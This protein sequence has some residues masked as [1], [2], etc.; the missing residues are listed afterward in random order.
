MTTYPWLALRGRKFYL[1]APVPQD[2]RETFGKAEITKSLRTSDR[3]EAIARLWKEAAIVQ[4]TFESHRRALARLHQPP[5]A[6]LTDAQIKA[7]GDAYYANLLE[8]DESVRLEGFEGRDFDEDAGWLDVLDGVNR[9]EFARGQLSVFMTDEAEDALASD[10]F[11]LRLADNSPSWP[12][13]IRAIYAA[14][15]EAA[16]ARRLRNAGDVIETPKPP[17]TPAAASSKPTLDEAK[18]FYIK[19][20]ITGNEFARR[21]RVV[22]IDAMMKNIEKA[23]GTIPALPDWTVD[24]AYK[25]RD[26]LLTKPKANGK[27]TLSP[28]SVRRGLNDIKG[29]FSLYKQKKMRALENPFSG[30]DLP[31]A[32]REAMSDMEARH[33][34]PEDVVEATRT[35]IL[36]RS[37]PDLKLIWRLLQGT[38]CRLGEVTGLRVTDVEVTGGTPHLK[39]IPHEMRRLKNASSRRNVPLVGDALEAAKDALRRAGS[40]AYLFPRYATAAGPNSASQSL[41]KWLRQVSSDPLHTVHSLRHNMA[42][43]CDLAGV[44]PNE[45]AAILGHMKPG[46]SEKHYGSEAVRLIQTAKAMDMVRRMLAEASLK[47]AM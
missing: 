6:E 23:L 3:K 7:I 9:Q 13:L 26:Y 39:L 1:R 25:V 40:S 36:E 19:E 41:M 11:N 35:L 38:G 37:G 46:A 15:I 27:S 10:P 32:L 34:L 5:L 44:N 18:D 33:P 42:D 24:D 14:T 17:S 29:V 21:K 8:E 22:R 31:A 16:K 47:A 20:K 43:W 28:A 4:A 2:I 12:K 30:L 45:K